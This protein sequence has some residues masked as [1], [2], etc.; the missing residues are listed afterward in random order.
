[1]YLAALLLSAMSQAVHMPVSQ[2]NQS[3][4]RSFPQIGS[5]SEYNPLLR[6]MFPLPPFCIL[7]VAKPMFYIAIKNGKNSS[8]ETDKGE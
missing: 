7:H 3:A 4:R 2:L 6:I 8:K 5:A 1:M